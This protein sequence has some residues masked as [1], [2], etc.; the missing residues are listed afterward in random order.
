MPYFCA[1]AV[2][3]APLVLLCV[4]VLLAGCNA[5]VGGSRTPR[6]AARSSH[7]R[8]GTNE[9]GDERARIQNL[10]EKVYSAYK[11]GLLRDT[12]SSARDAVTQAEQAVG[13]DDPL[14]GFALFNLGRILLEL[15]SY[16]AARPILERALAIFERALGPDDILIGH[17]LSQLA[18]LLML[19]GDFAGARPLDERALRIRER[20]LGRDSVWVGWSCF[21]LGRGL[22]RAGIDAEARP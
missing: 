16:T 12:L 7:S 5:S 15:N 2:V 20:R 13:P 18:Q 22:G 17:T 4:A 10:N 6:T 9:P 21:Y 1:E 8:L 11:L 3:K 14:T 19:T